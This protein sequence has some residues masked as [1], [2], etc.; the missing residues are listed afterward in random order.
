MRQKLKLSRRRNAFSFEGSEHGRHM[1]KFLA[2]SIDI[3]W[4]AFVQSS[5]ENE[6]F[7]INSVDES[8]GC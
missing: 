1:D 3:F 8:V 4:G 6:C 2:F 7:V 5:T